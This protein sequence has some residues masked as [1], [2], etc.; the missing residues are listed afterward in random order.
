MNTFVVPTPRGLPGAPGDLGPVQGISLAAGVIVAHLAVAL[1]VFMRPDAPVEVSPSQLAIMVEMVQSPPQAQAT[2]LPPAPVPP[3][4]TPVRQTAT[5]PAPVPLASRQPATVA[6][7]ALPVPSPEP[8]VPSPAPLAAPVAAPSPSPALPVVSAMTPAA[9]AAELPRVPAQPKEAG[10]VTDTDYLGSPPRPVFP[11]VSRELGEQGTVRLRVLVDEQGR[12][13]SILVAQSSGFPRL[14]QAA[15]SA[16]KAARFKPYQEG[17]V[18]QSRW[19]LAPF[20][21]NLTEP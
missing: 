6:D 9:P 11:R 15:I 16:L 4:P 10:P 2:A 7:R 17:G 18:P 3:T 20:T 13:T 14:D 12:P 8:R 1:V 21:F 19:V 5:P